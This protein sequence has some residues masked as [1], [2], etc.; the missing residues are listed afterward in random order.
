MHKIEPT[1][2][3]TGNEGMMPKIWGPAAWIYFHTITFNYP[4]QPNDKQKKWHE[5]FFKRLG[6]TIPCKE[7][8]NSYNRIIKKDSTKIIS[9][10]FD[11]R[12]TLTR[13]FYYVHE[14]VNKKLGVDYGITFE[15]VIK[16][17]ES[18]RSS[19]V[20]AQ[21]M[22]QLVSNKMECFKNA[23]NKECPLIPL[24]MAQ[25]FIEYA[26]QRGLE[27]EDFIF[28]NYNPNTIKLDHDLWYKR[29]KE[30][31]E[32]IAQMRENG[33]QSIEHNQPWSGYPT[34]PELKLIM[35]LS[36]NLSK[37][38]LIQ[39]IRTFP[40]YDSEYRKIYKLVT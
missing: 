27:E 28:I 16:K 7:C 11:S 39:I 20:N 15:D 24:K 8:A 30:C 6:Y 9:G 17:Y 36:S 19:C 18:Y 25:Q 38:Q 31:T 12:D 10:I 26:K 14:A 13:W 40:N 3:I 33:I 37:Q 22:C 35:R 29:N 32:I 5:T 4:I 34:I 1:E 21:N 2:T 23:N